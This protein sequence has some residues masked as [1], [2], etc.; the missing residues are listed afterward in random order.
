M[1][2]DGHFVERIPQKTAFGKAT[3]Y[4]NHWMLVKCGSAGTNVDEMGDRNTGTFKQEHY[5]YKIKVTPAPTVT[6]G[7]ILYQFYHY[8]K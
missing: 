4:A 5:Y 6:N 2:L 8:G 1:E 3:Q 7:C